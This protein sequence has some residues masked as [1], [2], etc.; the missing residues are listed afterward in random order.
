MLESFKEMIE[1]LTWGTVILVVGAGAAYFWFTVD[2]TPVENKKNEINA[3][4][5]RIEI[6]KNRIKEAEEFERNFE[7]RK[8][9][10]QKLLKTLQATQS[11]LPS[12][13]YLP[14]LL[15]DILDEA[16]K[17]GLEIDS[18]HPNNKEEQKEFYSMITFQVQ[19]KGSFLQ[20]FVFLDRLARMKRLVD[21]NKLTLL[22]DAAKENIKLG[23]LNG[24]LSAKV[25]SSA[26]GKNSSGVSFD[27]QLVAYRYNGSS[28]PDV[29]GGAPK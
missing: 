27:V 1:K 11:S 7:V 8:V 18:F 26:E 21:V 22:K 25:A 16:K 3:T 10:Y 24:D 12:E 14:D 17:V 13:F 6:A 28:A 5:G 15:A 9:E 4:N 19:V 23:V 2:R 20:I 29:A